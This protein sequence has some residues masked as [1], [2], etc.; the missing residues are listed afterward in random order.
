[1]L[2]VGILSKR[3]RSVF[4]PGHMPDLMKSV[5]FSWHLDLFEVNTAGDFFFFPPKIVMLLLGLEACVERTK[6]LRKCS[7]TEKARN[8]CPV[9]S[10]RETQRQRNPWH[11]VRDAGV[12][13]RMNQL[14]G[15]AQAP[16]VGGLSLQ[17]LAAF[18]KHFKHMF[19]GP[20]DQTPTLLLLVPFPL[21]ITEGNPCSSTLLFICY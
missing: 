13:L 21:L 3:P 19:S 14:R 9:A 8:S 1:M 15:P 5:D 4:P 10:F 18:V 6:T 12:A 17:S 2:K 7:S 16:G 20:C 11:F